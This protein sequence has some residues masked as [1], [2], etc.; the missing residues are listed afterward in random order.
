MCDRYEE[1]STDAIL[2]GL[3]VVSITISAIVALIVCL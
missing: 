3:L 1:V 2:Y